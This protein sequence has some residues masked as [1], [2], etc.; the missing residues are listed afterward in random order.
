MKV[1]IKFSYFKTGGLTNKTRL[2]IRETRGLNVRSY[3]LDQLDI[4]IFV[5]D[6]TAL[7]I[8]N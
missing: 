7:T 2:I 8:I 4:H 5:P 6:T 3:R 1:S